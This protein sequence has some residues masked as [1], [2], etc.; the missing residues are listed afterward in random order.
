MSDAA[1]RTTYVQVPRCWLGAQAETASA[2]KPPSHHDNTTPLMAMWLQES[3]KD[4]PYHAVGEVA[5]V[6]GNEAESAGGTQG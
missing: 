5:V 4:Q 1:D 6:I 3:M 2:N